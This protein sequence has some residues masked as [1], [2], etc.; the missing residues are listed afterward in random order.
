[1]REVKMALR[2]SRH[3]HRG[4]LEFIL[5]KKKILELILKR[6]RKKKEK[7]KFWVYCSSF[8]W[9]KK[10]KNHLKNYGLMD[11]PNIQKIARNQIEKC[12]KKSGKE[13]KKKQQNCKC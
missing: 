7:K 3:A 2:E 10:E 9:E 8:H 11:T 1:L 6:K 13:N 12:P 5:K 4:R